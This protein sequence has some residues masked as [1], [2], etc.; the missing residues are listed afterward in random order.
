MVYSKQMKLEENE[1]PGKSLLG[2]AAAAHAG[3]VLFS[4]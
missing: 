1:I 3:N 4:L 2:K